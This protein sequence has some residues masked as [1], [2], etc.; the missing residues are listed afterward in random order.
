MTD[1]QPG[2]YE[3]L[4]TRALKE[5]LEQFADPRLYE[6]VEVDPGESHST[7]AQFLEHALAAGLAGFRGKEASDR[8][9]RLVDRILNLLS[10]ELG[11]EWEQQLRITTP[12]KRLLA[13]HRSTDNRY[14]E[15][16]DTPLSRSALLTGTRLDP[17]L[18]CQLKKEIATADSVDILC[19]FVKWSGLR[20]ILDELRELAAQGGQN[21]LRIR[22]ITTSYMG[23]TDP[24]AI[25]ELSKLPNTEIRVSY[26]TK[27]TRLHAKAYIF[28]RE[29][30]FGSAYVGSA[31][32]SNAALSEG[33]EWTTKISQYELSYLW[34]KIT[35]TF[36]TYW[37]DDEFQPF[38]SEAPERL[39]T[40]IKS[41]RMSAAD[42]GAIVNFDLHP[43]PFQEEILD[44]LTAE[45]EVQKKNTHLV[46][47]ATGTGK[48]MIAA[49]DYA[50]YSKKLGRK[51]SFL[52]IAHRGEILKQAL[53]SFRG[54]LRDHNFG[55]LLVGGNNP[56]QTKH[57]FC[58]I[59]SYNSREL[60]KQAADEYD[61]VVVD[62]FHHAAATSYLKLLEFIR[63]RVLL[64][65]TA[66]PERSDGLDV[67]KWFG[68]RT[69]AEIRLPDAIN[70][71]LLCPFQYFGVSDA[72]D[73]DGLTWQR[74]GYKASEL[75]NIYTGNDVRAQLI[76]D[77]THEILLNP[78]Q[79]RGLGFCVSQ[80]HAEFMARY[81]SDHGLPAAALTADS[82]VE[83]RHAVQGQLCSRE[84]NFIFVVDLYN[85]GVDIP[86]VDTL[87]FLRPTESLTVFLQQF[88]RGMRLHDDKECLTILD[89]IGAQHREFRF[90]SR[91]RAL[92]T[93]PSGRLD[94]EIENGFPHLPSGCFVQLERV[95]QQRVLDNVRNSVR[96]NKN[97]MVKSL[98]DLGGYLGHVPQIGEALE[99]LD[100]NLDELLKR[101]L[102][103]SLL[104]E[105]EL[106]D[107]FS[108]PDEKQLEKGIRRLSHVDCAAQIQSWLEHLQEGT[109]PKSQEEF[110]LQEMLYV[111]LWSKQGLGWSI[112]ESRDRLILNQA[113]FE[114]V[115][116]VLKYRLQTAPVHPAGRQP[117]IS[118]PLTIHSQY[119]RDEIL[120][121]LGHWSLAK[122]PDHREGVLHLKDSKIDAFFITLQKTEDEYSPT[123]MY[124]DYLISHALFHWQTQSNTS[125]ESPT[126]KRYIQHHSQG[127]TPLLFVR[128][129]KKSSSGLSFPYYYLGPCE[130]VSHTGNRPMSI[131][132]KLT[133]SV[134]A[135]LYREMARQAVG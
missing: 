126:G 17:S 82:P 64:G 48:T 123:T 46:V 130:Y 47:A 102:W 75:D 79:A 8:Q 32:L 80:A 128:E 81:F 34:S 2:L 13:I 89:F 76:M 112:E 98:R 92:S 90:A 53:A 132:W 35:G 117:E 14:E 114:D 120:I 69:S 109:L 12:L 84:I 44:V 36:E 42:T 122:R 91:F 56:S 121:G 59:Q 74:G 97:R 96:L 94:S 33:L 55:D 125:E 101:G 131:I 134:P 52:F 25:E 20:V 70:R 110:R 39:R 5:Q 124:E 108:I 27:R 3:Q 100:T 85:E 62:E 58:S 43:Y 41:E 26:D 133:H 71:R 10:E 19:S 93:K 15:R 31:N 66:T 106:I 21:D 83:L 54:V 107:K 67:L 24:K 63:P 103:S 28:Y 104:A 60:W 40:A 77:K 88:G 11:Q 119:T 30:S 116:T 105:A 127:Y 51:P 135:K 49:F 115:L 61:Y 129:Q 1:Y 65:L 23:A 38:S 45:R 7:I 95:A 68:G 4:L 29:T 37:Q 18:G 22:M 78:F 118:G 73:L 6:L 87:L 16:P 9:R 50:R 86:E 113:A 72:V 111:S 57:L 99:Y